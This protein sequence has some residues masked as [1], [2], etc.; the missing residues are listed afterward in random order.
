MQTNPRQ[1]GVQGT[2]A[3]PKPAPTFNPSFGGQLN[4]RLLGAMGAYGESKP[5]PSF[6]MQTNPRQ[7]SMANVLPVRPPQ[8]NPGP[9]VVSPS[10]PVGGLG[11]LG[12]RLPLKGRR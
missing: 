7:P 5:A 4:P 1:L 6:P 9:S 8:V 11:S 10:Q 12:K 3:D 2:M